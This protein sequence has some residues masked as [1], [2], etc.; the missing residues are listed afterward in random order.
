MLLSYSR[1]GGGKRQKKKGKR[2][3]RRKRVAKR[4]KCGLLNVIYI[5]LIFE[6]ISLP[7]LGVVLRFIGGAGTHPSMQFMSNIQ[8]Q[9]TYDMISSR[10][11][12]VLLGRLKEK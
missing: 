12:P 1:Q 9:F 3:E 11:T 10:G 8:L 5:P 2:E 4:K 7:F 6:S